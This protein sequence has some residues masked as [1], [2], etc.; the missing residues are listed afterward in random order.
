MQADKKKMKRMAEVVPDSDW[1]VLQNFTPHSPWSG[2]GLLD[3]I[4][5]DANHLIRLTNGIW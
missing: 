3:Q 2:Q 1:Q 5:H 4:A